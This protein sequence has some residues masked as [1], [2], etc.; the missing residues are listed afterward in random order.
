[1][2][3][4]VRAAT[5]ERTGQLGAR[6]DDPGSYSRK[7]DTMIYVPRW[8]GSSRTQKQCWN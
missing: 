2:T 3:E 8:T 1:M 5:D 6:G 7:K 4:E